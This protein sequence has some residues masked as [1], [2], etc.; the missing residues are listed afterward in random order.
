MQE[1]RKIVLILGNGFDLDL[2]LKTSYKDFWESEF[3]PRNYPA[4]L[5]RHLNGKWGDNLESVRWYDLE[6]ELHEYALNGDKTDVVNEAERSYL[7]NHNDYRINN[8]F[9]YLG[10]PDEFNTLVE[11]GY[12]QIVDDRLVKRARVPYHE[13]FS[14]SVLERDKKAFQLIKDNLRSFL[15]HIFDISYIKESL[16]LNVL[17]AA[18][19]A[20]E[21]G[22]L[23]ILYSFNYTKLP[24]G[25]GKALQDSVQYVHGRC[26]DN[27]IVGTID[28][29]TI[30]E[31]YDFLQK[32]FDP[33]FNPPAIVA[34]LIDA[35]EIIIFGHSIGENDRQYFKAFFKQ[36]A[37]Y[38]LPKRKD[39]TVFTRDDSSET[40]I[41]RSLQQM[42]DGNLSTLYCLNHIQ[43]IKSENLVEGQ[44]KMFNF[45][46]NHHV[47][48][49]HAEDIIG[50]LLKN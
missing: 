32:S 45:L 36:Q 16:A 15:Y 50:K 21:A 33:Q 42:T 10:V 46:V 19:K 37:D 22:E 6:N 49:H 4:P 48:Q 23:L 2:G 26:S 31:K 17:L 5:I 3:C 27:I 9:T 41:K 11:K 7:L 1:P 39:I 35:D 47:E 28:D 43:I 29:I 30:D 24:E 34:D 25:C 40:Q 18:E 20:R 8:Q 38:S 12:I 14:L 44:R 13:D